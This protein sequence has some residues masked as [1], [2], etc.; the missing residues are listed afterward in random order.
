MSVAQIK[1]NF[2]KLLTKM[3]TKFRSM[4]ST[5]DDLSNK[6]SRSQIEIEDLKQ[7]SK[8]D[9]DMLE[10]KIKIL[11]EDMATV[12]DSARL[13]LKGVKEALKSKIEEQESKLERHCL[14]TEG[15]DDKF[16]LSLAQLQATAA[17]NTF[18]I[19]QNKKIVES[20]DNKVRSRNLVI[21][22]IN[23]AANED[24]KQQVCDCI[25][26]TIDGLKKEQ[27]KSAYRMGRAR[28]KK[29]RSIVVVVEDEAIRDGILAKAS[30]IKKN[31]NNKY[32]WLNR[33][34]NDSSRRKRNLVKSCFNLLKHNKYECSMKGST[35]HLDGKQF[36]YDELTLLPEKCRP[37]NAKSR[38]FDDDLSMAFHSEHVFCSNMYNAMFVYKGQLYTSAEQAYQVTKV[39]EAGYS[40][41]AADMLGFANPYYIKSVGGSTETPDGWNDKSEG[42]MREI[43]N[44][45]FKQ[46]RDLAD[47]LVQCPSTDFYEMTLDRK[48]GTGL[49]LPHVTKE[50]NSKAF[51]GDNLVGC[52]LR[53]IKA[54]LT[55]FVSTDIKSPASA[56]LS[57]EGVD[58]NE[59][60]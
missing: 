6:L 42:I 53:D 14:E 36:G 54:E 2:E 58:V 12:K 32:M 40:K 48:W 52:I 9:K 1:G 20:L 51:K 44:E 25:S 27:I 15:L 11:Q 22:G 29:P 18:E 17:A 38:L 13:E 3:D 7:Q 45:K 31:S 41:L 55:G 49:R 37:E 30:I 19:N 10:E 5:I 26:P 28:G 24:I 46:N 56:N 39:T 34:Q 21:D 60:D 8:I 35:I 4:Q 59:L 23:E 43:I 16:K 57:G 47:K 50:I 33:D